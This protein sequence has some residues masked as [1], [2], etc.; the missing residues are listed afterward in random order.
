V[1]RDRRL[2]GEVTL[3]QAG[4]AATRKQFRRKAI[5]ALSFGEL[6]QRSRSRGRGLGV[7][8]AL[9]LLELDQRA[10]RVVSRA[11]W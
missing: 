6:G 8:E 4:P 9:Q 11:E 7:D 1:L 3:R 5:P 2:G 10:E